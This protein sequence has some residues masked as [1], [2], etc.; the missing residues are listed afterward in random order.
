MKIKLYIGLDVHK[1]SIVVATAKAD[2]SDAQSY[3]KWGGS[4]LSAERGLCK[5]L[6]AHGVQKS[7]VSIVYEAGTYHMWYVN[8]DLTGVRH[9]TSADGINFTTVGCGYFVYPPFYCVIPIF[10]E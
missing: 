1:N 2:G 3:G 5:M 6:K 8:P 4:N 9:A 10:G 7:E